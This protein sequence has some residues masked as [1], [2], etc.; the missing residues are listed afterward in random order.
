VTLKTEVMNAENLAL[1][2]H[3][4]IVTFLHFNNVSQF[5][6]FDQI[7]ADLVSIIHLFQKHFL[8]TC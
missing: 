1:P 4:K 3:C 5:Y 6:C 8:K 2:S 7:N